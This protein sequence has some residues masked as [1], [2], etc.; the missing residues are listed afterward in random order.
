MSKIGDRSQ[1][2][3][4]PVGQSWVPCPDARTEAVVPS[5]NHCS[6]CCGPDGWAI[7]S[8]SSSTSSKRL[9]SLIFTTG[10]PIMALSGFHGGSR[11]HHLL[12]SGGSFLP[13]G[14]PNRDLAVE[15]VLHIGKLLQPLVGDQA[16]HCPALP[17]R[18]R[19][20]QQRQA[21]T[22]SLSHAGRRRGSRTTF[23]AADVFW[24]CPSRG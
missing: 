21:E 10:E 6:I 8:P 13:C 5:S 18:P 11:C 16:H 1:R 9:K 7:C 14:P 4:H 20:R 23:A 15:A 12:R 2:L 24:L 17:M 19:Q 22:A 3:L